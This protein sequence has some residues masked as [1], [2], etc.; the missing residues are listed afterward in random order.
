[1]KWI[2]E[3]NR[4][5]SRNNV[6]VPLYAGFMMLN[7]SSFNLTKAS[8]SYSTLYNTLYQFLRALCESYLSL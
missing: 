1:M 5:F 6:D 2:V 4:S 8:E 7:K 3:I